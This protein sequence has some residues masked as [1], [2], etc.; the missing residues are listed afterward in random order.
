MDKTAII[1]AG[2]CG[3][4]LGN[5]TPKQFLRLAGR[6]M[7]Y[8]SVH[9][10]EQNENVDSII[11]V[12][13][14]EYLGYTERE[15]VSEFSL[16]KVSAVIAGGEQRYHSVYA[17]L[18]ALSSSCDI[19]IVHD[20]AR[21]FVT[22][23]LIDEIINAAVQFGAAIP[24]VSPKD[25]IKQIYKRKVLCT[26]NRDN[27]ISVQTP[28]AFKYSVIMNAYKIAFL[29]NKFASDDAGLVELTGDPV[30]VLDGDDKNI[31]ITTSNDFTYAE[32]LLSEGR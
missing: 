11:I 32:W 12:V 25:T 3:K 7:L 8:Y 13:P 5:D 4:R 26:L 9:A 19:V 22:S 30:W 31:K 6:P 18:N 27:M 2:G 23:N 10:F 1:A 24:G 29:Q 17:G 15:I 14:K 16:K 21:P 20:G 28:Q